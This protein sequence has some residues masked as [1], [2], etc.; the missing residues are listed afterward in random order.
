M[1]N[2]ICGTL[3]KKKNKDG[4]DSDDHSSPDTEKKEE[5]VTYATI[6]HS[7]T[8]TTGVIIDSHAN[9]CDYAIVKPPTCLAHQSLIKEDCA[10]D[11]VF[12]G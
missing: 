7:N 1:G 8:K 12:M 9:D 3:R 11:Y 5:D 4:D 6:D 10:D 2:Y